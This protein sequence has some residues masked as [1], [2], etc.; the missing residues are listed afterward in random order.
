MDTTIH[1]PELLGDLIRFFTVATEQR[2][3]RWRFVSEVFFGSA[4]EAETT[5]ESDYI[6]TTAD[7]AI[8]AGLA[9]CDRELAISQLLDVLCDWLDDGVITRD[10]FESADHSLWELS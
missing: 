2:G 8:K 4:D 6:F 10:E 7:E 1:T 3:D 5:N 9:S